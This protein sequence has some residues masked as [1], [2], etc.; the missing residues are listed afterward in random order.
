MSYVRKKQSRSKLWH[1]VR[2]V[3]E[4]YWITRCGKTILDYRA[5]IVEETEG[6]V[7]EVCKR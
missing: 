6:D 1:V 3:G 4:C 5:V 7:C 2:S